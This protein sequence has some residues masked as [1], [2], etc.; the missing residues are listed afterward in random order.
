MAGPR[1]VYSAESRT[2]HL[3]DVFRAMAGGLV[4]S[5]YMA[6]RL[7]IKDIRAESAKSAFGILWDFADP[8]VLGGIFY[9]LMRQRIINPGEMT[10][11]YAVYVIYGLLLYTTFCESIT[12]SLDVMQKSKMILTHLKLP[13]E[14]MILSVFFRVMFNG[15]FRIAVMFVFSVALHRSAVAEGLSAFSPLGFVFFL[16]C[17]PLLVLVGMSIGVFLAP[18]NA[19]YS[20]VGRAVRIVLLPLRYASPV[21]YV[22]PKTPFFDWV[23]T[24]NPIALLLTNL[25]LL[26]TANTLDD[27]MGMALRCAIFLAVFLVG[28]LNFHLAIPVLAER[29]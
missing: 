5:R 25:R 7:C 10:M 29:A 20:D 4:R 12:L 14:A 11:P 28:W 23:N 13:P 9:L 22:L 3:G 18:F 19:I 6:Y 21:L 27:P 8:L 16:A 17:F 2:T 1:H 24:F 15:F 26:A